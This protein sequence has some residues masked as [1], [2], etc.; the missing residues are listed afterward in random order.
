[1]VEAFQ[2]LCEV[3]SDKATVE[4]TSRYTGRIVA[5]HHQ[6][7]AMVPVGQALVD[8]QLAGTSAPEKPDSPGA[9]PILSP[10]ATPVS[11]KAPA[12]TNDAH[13][14][15]RTIIPASPAARRLAKD[16]G[17]DLSSVTGTGHGGHVTKGDVLEAVRSAALPFA[18]NQAE[19]GVEKSAVPIAEVAPVTVEEGEVVR[20]Q[21]RGYARAMV[22]TMK[23]AAAV[24]HFY[25]CDEVCMDALIALRAKLRQDGAHER[26][27]YL[28]FI[29]KAASLA[30]D[31]FPALNCQLSADE[32]EL[33]RFSFHNLGVAISTPA[34]LVVP[35]IKGVQRKS[36]QEISGGV[37]AFRT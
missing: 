23:A 17:L 27:T 34:G 28:P 29:L 10:T 5:L 22:K 25:F 32:S 20:Q 14:G 12:R 19:G 37:T 26:L 18:G 35:N 21:L 31:D 30:L 9:R 1:V 13:A 11:H 16:H 7:G 4:I 33:L 15:G 8:I 36:I 2:A 24:P 3:Q 6:P